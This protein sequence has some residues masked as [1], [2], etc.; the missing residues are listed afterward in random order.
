MVTYPRPSTQRP[1]IQA[2]ERR[3]PILGAGPQ[4]HAREGGMEKPESEG[5]EALTHLPVAEPF[6]AAIPTQDAEDRLPLGRVAPKLG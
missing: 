4:T 5:T 6:Q 1:S 2:E 3:G